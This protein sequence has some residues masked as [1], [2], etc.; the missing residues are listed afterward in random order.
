MGFVVH[1]STKKE[2]L[3]LWTYSRIFS[4]AFLFFS[5]FFN[6]KV[7]VV[8]WIESNTCSDSLLASGLEQRVYFILQTKK[9]GVSFFCFILFYVFKIGLPC[10][11]RLYKFI[12]YLCFWPDKFIP[13]FR[14]LCWWCQWLSMIAVLNL[15][16]LCKVVGFLINQRV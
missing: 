7:E 13:A 10:K 1:E 2:S 8:V 12:A 3:I 11:W 9:G 4:A 14:K 6:C 5:C 16:D 15:L